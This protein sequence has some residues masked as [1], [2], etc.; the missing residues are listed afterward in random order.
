MNVGPDPRGSF[1]DLLAQ[2][3]SQRF[4]GKPAVSL[5]SILSLLTPL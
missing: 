2:H 4:A 3:I 5:P 1:A